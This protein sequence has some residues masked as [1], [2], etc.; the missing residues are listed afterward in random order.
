MEG[1]GHEADSTHAVGFKGLD[2][3]HVSCRHR[4]PSMCRTPRFDD[5]QHPVSTM[6]NTLPPPRAA[7][8]SGHWPMP[9]AHRTQPAPTLPPPP[10]QAC[11]V[12]AP[13]R[14]P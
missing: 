3:C 4:A 10:Q 6:R 2:L 13:S 5:A 14:Q 9:L 12:A 11:S 1:G 8:A 7:P